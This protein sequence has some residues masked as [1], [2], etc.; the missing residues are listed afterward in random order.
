MAKTQTKLQIIPL[1]GLGEIGKNMTVIRVDDEI[2]LIDS[3][4]MFP[5][6]EMLG[7][8]LVIPDITYLLENKDMIKA[9]VLTHGHED[10]IGALPY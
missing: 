10:H 6:E 9:I 5:E 4:L 7:V 8:D 2:L 3:G 1:G